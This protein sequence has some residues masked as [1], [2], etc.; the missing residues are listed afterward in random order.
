MTTTKLGEIYFNCI[1]YIYTNKFDEIS[2]DQIFDFLR[3]TCKYTFY[4]NS[5]EIENLNEDLIYTYH[6]LTGFNFNSKKYK[7]LTND[8][9]SMHMAFKYNVKATV[10][11][12]YNRHLKEI[13][14]TKRSIKSEKDSNRSLIIAYASLGIAF[15]ALLISSVQAGIEI[16]NYNKDNPKYDMKIFQLESEQVIQNKQIIEL[17]K[18]KD[19]TIINVVT[20]E[21][22]SK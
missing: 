18:K 11:E 20:P 2:Y 15:L 3:K 10:Y 7:N 6:R 21:I 9:I 22:K 1:E 19:T 14:N 8:A 4:Q 16:Y 17:L 13:E 12:D 5:R